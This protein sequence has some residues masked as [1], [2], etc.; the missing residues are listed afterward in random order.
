MKEGVL[1]KRIRRKTPLPR[2][3]SSE[4][5]GATVELERL[6][7]CLLYEHTRAVSDAKVHSWLKRGAD[8]AASIA[9]ATPYP[10]LVF[11]LLLDEKLSEARRKAERQRSIYLRSQPIVALA[12]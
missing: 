10:L 6:K 3:S 8:E 4:R 1:E 7:N 12:E 5:R 9:W 2:R 11:P